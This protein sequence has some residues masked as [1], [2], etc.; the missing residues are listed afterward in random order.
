MLNSDKG[1]V[2]LVRSSNTI[3][4]FSA[5]TCLA[6]ISLAII[7]FISFSVKRV[8]VE[9]QG[10]TVSYYTL[11]PTVATVLKELSVNEDFGSP[12]NPS[13]LKEGE[14][15]NFYTLSKDLDQHI[16]QGT[17]IK[18]IH[19]RIEKRAEKRVFSVPSKRKWDIFMAP[20][21]QRIIDPGRK[22]IIK[23]TIITYYRNGKLAE[24][25][26]I[27]SEVVVTPKPMIL[28]SGSYDVVSRQG[29]IRG[30]RA[31]K[32]EATAY[33]HTGYRTATGAATRRGII[34]VDPRI[35][36]LGTRLYVE[37]YGHGVAADTGGAI[38]GRRID[39]FLESEAAARKW[40]R[41]TVDVYILEKQAN[42]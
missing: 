4:I 14:E 38:K 29:P 32:F 22:G 17:T 10:K 7:F 42:M 36:P 5:Y 3:S 13:T 26:K 40:G 16:S 39:V 20:G 6:L 15:L 8:S 11:A 18:I 33:T 27:S 25:N 37:G 12:R 30:G 9:M 19:N 2:Q 23:D 28:A 21:K 35:I 41:R 31:F 1:K 34:A 24:R